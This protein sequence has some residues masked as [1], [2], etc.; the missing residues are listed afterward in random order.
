MVQATWKI[1]GF[2]KADANL[3]AEEIYAIGEEATP[4]QV[5]EK[6]RD[7]NSE[8]HKCFEWDDSIAAEKYR[9]VQARQVLRFVVVRNEPPEEEKPPIRVFFKP[10]G[11]AG[12][13]P[14]E[15]IIKQ[16]DEYQAL[17][18]QAMIELQAFKAKYACLS[19]LEELWEAIDNA[20]I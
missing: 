12:Y 8:L 7:E 4:E 17:L 18:E 6:A 9:L 14:T 5:L 11:S 13:K 2:Y 16:K 10:K 1:P 19:E 15:I 3:V 20:I